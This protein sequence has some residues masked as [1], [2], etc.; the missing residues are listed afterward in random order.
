MEDQTE[1]RKKTGFPEIATPMGL[2]SYLDD[3]TSRLKNTKYLYHYTTLSRA[4]DIFKNKCWHLGNARDMNDLIEYN[5][6]DPT[7]WKNIFFASFMSDAKESIGMWSMYSQPWEKGVK[8]AIPKKAVFEWIERTTEILEV[9]KS[10]YQLTGRKVKTEH[11]SEV[12]LSCVA[13]SN[14]ASLES[15]NSDE[16]LTWSNKS[17][18]LL[19]NATT[20]PELTGYVKDKAWDYEKEVRLKAEFQNINGFERVAIILPDEV[21]NQMIISAGPLFEGNLLKELAKEIGY[22][23]EVEKSLFTRR[24][25]LK[26]IC[27]MC[28]YRKNN[29]YS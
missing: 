16:V 18:R 10:N 12:R 29:I 13:Y 20:I 14:S 23:F 24:L 6:G 26:S 8:I 27:K 2:V 4:I 22:E 15:T 17:N 7:R 1:K 19:L 3:A 25:N 21:L 28:P 5:N 11:G 9:S